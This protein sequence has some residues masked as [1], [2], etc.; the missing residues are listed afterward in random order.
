MVVALG[1]EQDRT[2]LKTRV[3]RL[4]NIWPQLASLLPQGIDSID[5]RYQ[6]GLALSAAGLK[7]PQ[8]G[9]K[10]V[11]PVVKKAATSTS[12]KTKKQ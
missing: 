12:G 3:D 6:N 7:V 2:T 11:Q 5:M 9:N 4:V 1:R 8:D 10:P